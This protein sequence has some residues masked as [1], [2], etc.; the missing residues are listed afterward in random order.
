MKK[1]LKIIIL[2]LILSVSLI[3]CE[4]MTTQEKI[5][6]VN[7]YWEIT[8]AK[9]IHSEAKAYKFNQT[10]DYIEVKE[11]GQGYRK[12]LNPNLDGKFKVIP[13]QEKLKLKME[14][15]SLRFYYSTKMSDWKETLIAMDKNSFKVKNKQGIIYTYNRFEGYIE[16]GKK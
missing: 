6:N 13:G 3:S 15:D 12:K 11:N 4:S 16:H 2:C 14:N 7:G 5:N 10:V 8:K 1:K 9:P